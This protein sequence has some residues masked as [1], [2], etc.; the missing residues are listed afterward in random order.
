MPIYKLGITPIYCE[1]M[2]FSGETDD[3][4]I[5]VISHA[6]L[7]ENGFKPLV[8]RDGKRITITTL[9]DDYSAYYKNSPPAVD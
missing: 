5:A 4:R 1:G 3:V 2:T 7:I 9:I 8:F 6:A